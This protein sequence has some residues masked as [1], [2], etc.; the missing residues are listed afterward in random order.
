[1]AFLSTALAMNALL[2]GQGDR[3][4]LIYIGSYDGDV[5]KNSLS[6][7]LKEDPDFGT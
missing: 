2:E 6:E 4:G 5:A 1:M 3:F 7:A